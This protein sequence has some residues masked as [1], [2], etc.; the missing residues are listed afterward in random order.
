[1]PPPA[2]LPN[3]PACPTCCGPHVAC[4]PASLRN[5]WRLVCSARKIL[6]LRMWSNGEGSRA[7]DQS[8]AQKGYEVLCVS[9]VGAAC[10]GQVGA[11]RQS[12]GCCAGHVGAA[13]CKVQAASRGCRRS[14]HLASTRGCVA[15]ELC[16]GAMPQACA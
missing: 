14:L 8:V 4:L 1:M 11:V 15:R 12:G 6:G 10:A 5:C 13:L 9:Q 2:C 3:L 7:W 16:E